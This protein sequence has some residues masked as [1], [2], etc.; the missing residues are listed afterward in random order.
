MPSTMD[1]NTLISW[2]LIFLSPFFD[3]YSV[4]IDKVKFN[5]LNLIQY[6]FWG[7]FGAYFLNFLKPPLLMTA[8]A[9]FVAAPALWF[10]ALNRFHLA[11]GDRA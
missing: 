7:Q 6:R 4:F 3:S 9:A 10:L 2:A 11:F 5:K 8:V 1:R